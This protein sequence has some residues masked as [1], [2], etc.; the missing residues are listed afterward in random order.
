[1]TDETN[2]EETESNT[3]RT[4]AGVAVT[5]ASCYLSFRFGRRVVRA[6]KARRNDQPLVDQS[7]AIATA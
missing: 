2:V 3:I 5:G 4:I 1:M 6:I 7:E